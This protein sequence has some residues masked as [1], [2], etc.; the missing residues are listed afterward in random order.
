MLGK[1]IN[2]NNYVTTTKFTRFANYSWRLSRYEPL[3]FCVGTKGQ[4]NF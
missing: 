1:A 3:C 4:E 2:H